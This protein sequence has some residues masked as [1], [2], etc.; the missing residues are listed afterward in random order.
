[1]YFLIDCEDRRLSCSADK[2][3][4][5][6]LWLEDV[7]EIFLWPGRHPVYFE[8]EVSP[9]GR[10]L[11]LLVPNNN[12]S[13]MGWRPWHYQGERLV[14]KNVV[15]RGGDPAP[16]AAVNGWSVEVFIP[17]V[18]LTGLDDLPPRP[19]TVWRMNVYRLDYDESPRAMW[20]W[21]TISGKSFHSYKEF[22]QVEFGP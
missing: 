4:F 18:L 11:P 3:D 20:A 21:S 6:D 15:V 16:G 1:M 10:E 17:F 12:G 8:Y 2:Q 14:Q 7:V 9:L 13:F 22:G 19:G 5:D